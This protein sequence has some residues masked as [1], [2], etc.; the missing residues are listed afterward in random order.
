MQRLLNHPFSEFLRLDQLREQGDIMCNK[1][2]LNL[3]KILCCGRIHL[4]EVNDDHEA[5]IIAY[6]RHHM[7]G[8][9][10]AEYA[11]PTADI[12]EYASTVRMYMSDRC[13]FNTE[14]GYSGCGRSLL[15]PGDKLCVLYG[16]Y[17]PYIL[18][19]DN[20]YYKLIGEAYIPEFMHSRAMD[21]L[22]AGQLEKEVFVLK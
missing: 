5:Y 16:G 6:M 10:S 15:Q 2:L 7:E 12:Q 3:G 14:K 9:S 4:R 18:R 21:M 13:L 17:V 1:S 8:A 20:R 22:D 11:N 19:P